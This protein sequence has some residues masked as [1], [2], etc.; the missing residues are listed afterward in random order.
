MKEKVPGNLVRHG[1]GGGVIKDTEQISLTKL[2]NCMIS[3]LEPL[4][5]LLFSTLIILVNTSK[6]ITHRSDKKNSF[7][8][9][10]IRRMPAHD[11]TIDK[12]IHFF[13]EQGHM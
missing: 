10:T 13:P 3:T 4:A 6:I 2:I 8:N 5:I 11:M 7:L 9:L 12:H 1:G